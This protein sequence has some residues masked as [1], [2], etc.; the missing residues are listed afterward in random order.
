VA[1]QG[2][3][4]FEIFQVG[5]DKCQGPG[6][7]QQNSSYFFWAEGYDQSPSCGPA[8]PPTPHKA[9]KGNA[10]SGLHLFTVIRTGTNGVNLEA[11]IDGVVQRTGSWSHI[12]GIC[13]LTVYAA[14]WLN[15][16]YN[17]GD[18]SGGFLA[19]AQNWEAVQYHKGS[20]TTKTATTCNVLGPWAHQKCSWAPSPPGKFWTWDT[21]Y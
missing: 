16:L 21:R 4:S 3:T 13:W 10:T 5:Y 11:R 12:V 1:I 17:V 18:Q 7:P 19:N 15:E 2:N 14:D 6:C 9:P 8:S 20:W